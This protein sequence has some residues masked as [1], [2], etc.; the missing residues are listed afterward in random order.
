[1]ITTGPLTFPKG[2]ADAGMLAAPPNKER[3]MDEFMKLFELN[4]RIAFYLW[5]IAAA[6]KYVLVGV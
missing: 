6:S 5:V 3:K 2:E 4:V 1:V